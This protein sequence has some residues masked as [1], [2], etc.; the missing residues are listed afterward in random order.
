MSTTGNRIIIKEPMEGGRGLIINDNSGN[1]KK[2]FDGA[3]RVHKKCGGLDFQSITKATGSDEAYRGKLMED[4]M[5]VQ[6]YQV[7]CNNENYDEAKRKRNCDNLEKMVEEL[8]KEQERNLKVFGKLKEIDNKYQGEYAIP[9]DSQALPFDT[10]RKVFGDN[11]GEELIKRIQVFAA[12][13]QATRHCGPYP[14]TQRSASSSHTR[15]Q[16]RRHS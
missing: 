12:Q 16:Q 6:H 4:L 9:L 14:T 5:L 10:L 13:E 1:Y 2:L 15:T 11:A 8:G 7:G 3:L